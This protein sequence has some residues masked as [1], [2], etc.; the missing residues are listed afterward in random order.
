MFHEVCG[1]HGIDDTVYLVDSAT[2][3]NDACRRNGLDFGYG[4]RRNRGTARQ[5]FDEVNSQI[6]TFSDFFSRAKLE[7]VNEW[8][9]VFARDLDSTFFRT[10]S[11]ETHSINETIL[12]NH[13]NEG[14]LN[15]I[16]Y[17]RNHTIVAISNRGDSVT[18]R[19]ARTPQLRDNNSPI[20]RRR[21]NVISV[22]IL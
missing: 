16:G 8:F 5:V 2:S 9:R 1:K 18:R 20:V 14:H 19:P 4:R 12:G 11:Y 21:Y 15:D 10:Q 7:T 17:V 13:S 6:T 3:L 22:W